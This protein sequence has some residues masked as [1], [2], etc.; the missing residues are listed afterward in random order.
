MIIA[1]GLAAVDLTVRLVTRDRRVERVHLVHH[2]T[3]AMCT[4]KRVCDILLE[5]VYDLHQHRGVEGGMQQPQNSRDLTKK[6]MPRSVP[7]RRAP[8]LLA[9]DN[10]ISGGVPHEALVDDRYPWPSRE[11][12]DWPTGRYGRR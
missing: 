12:C 7:D 6:T 11:R 2:L 3:V 4:G 5:P 10:R 8:E 1:V 9:P